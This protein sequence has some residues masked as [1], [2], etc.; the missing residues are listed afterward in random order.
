MS[1]F[2]ISDFCQNHN[3]E[4]KKHYQT[5]SK[6][7]FIDKYISYINDPKF[8]KI[9]LM[10][11]KVNK[12]YIKNIY[13]KID[14]ITKTYMKNELI[15][16]SE[17]GKFFKYYSFYR[18]KIDLNKKDDLI[19]LTYKQLLY[20][21]VISLLKECFYIFSDYRSCLYYMT[22]SI[23]FYNTDKKT[24]NN[25]IRH[26]KDNINTLTQIIT[27]TYLSGN[28]PWGL[29]YYC[30]AY[31]MYETLIIIEKYYPDPLKK[32]GILFTSKKKL[33]HKKIMSTLIDKFNQL[34][35][36]K[37]KKS[38]T[39]SEFIILLKQRK[40]T[41]WQT[42]LFVFNTIYIT[43]SLKNIPDSLVYGCTNIYYQKQ[44]NKIGVMAYLL[45][46]YI[47]QENGEKLN[48]KNIFNG[49]YT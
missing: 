38:R 20:P 14:I 43:Y 45:N 2:K 3:I 11:I 4:F 23:D 9:I 48:N 33:N 13:E 19:Y 32:I 21:H 25:I 18:K 15:Q 47:L 41:L 6:Y 1:N 22:P 46:K 37:I 28:N 10:F 17:I 8:Y 39:V 30:S 26:F 35:D 12:D 24:I 5:I 31:T 29:K 44:N 27:K 40:Y 7:E 42:V 36:S 49:F 16:K 34:S